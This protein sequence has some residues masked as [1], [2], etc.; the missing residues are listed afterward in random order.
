MVSLSPAGRGI[1]GEGENKKEE[2]ICKDGNLY[3]FK[4]GLGRCVC[5]CKVL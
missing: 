5:I 1:K 3:K 2:G 4:K